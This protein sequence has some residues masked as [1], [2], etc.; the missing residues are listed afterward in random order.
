MANLNAAIRPPER[1]RELRLRPNTTGDCNFT[2]NNGCPRVYYTNTITNKLTAINPNEHFLPQNDIYCVFL[3]SNPSEPNIISILRNFIVVYPQLDVKNTI[4][5]IIKVN[6]IYINVGKSGFI[7]QNEFQKYKIKYS[8]EDNDYYHFEIEDY[9]KQLL[10]IYYASY[11]RIYTLTSN[12]ELIAE[13]TYNANGNHIYEKRI[14]PD[15]RVTNIGG[16]QFPSGSTMYR[17]PCSHIFFQTYNP[18]FP[19]V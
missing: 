4:D 14:Y 2:I 9:E 11:A 8:R 19:N 10:D 7:G 16:G 18:A 12:S 1:E 6:R 13:S 17:L 15:G 3:L 5:D